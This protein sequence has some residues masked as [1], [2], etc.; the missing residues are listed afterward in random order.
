MLRQS[1]V[2]S[3]VRRDLARQAE[4]YAAIGFSIIPTCGKKPACQWKKYQQERLAPGSFQRLFDRPDV[5]GLAVILGHVSGDLACRDF[6]ERESYD[7]WAADHRDL[8]STLPTVETPRGRHVYFRT[9]TGTSIIDLGDGELRCSGGYCL[10]P[11][12]RHPSGQ[13]YRWLT[14]LPDGELPLLD[15]SQAG[16]CNTADTAHTETLPLRGSAVSTAPAVLQDVEKAIL[17]TLPTGQGQRNQCIFRFV[18]H[19]KGIVPDAE[20]GQLR[21]YVQEWHR[22]ALPKIGTKP[23]LETWADFVHA[24]AKVKAPIGQGLVDAAFHRAIA[25]EPPFVA[26]ELYGSIHE[27]IVILAALC[28]ELQRIAGAREF[29]LD[30]RTAG[31]LIGRDHTTAWRYLEVLCADGIL[32]V[33][34]KGSKAS[35]KASSFRFINP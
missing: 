18:R 9:Q 27:P 1:T 22:R 23:F 25:S 3:N 8:A 17:A 26:I 30:C 29:F 7:R 19:L 28:R 12:S 11:P 31:R 34:T 35:R 2:A 14:E 24:W 10:L 33:G 20:A 5:T 13:I 6:D 16:L 4:I 15:P 21:P 32:A